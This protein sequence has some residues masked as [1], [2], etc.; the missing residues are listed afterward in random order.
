M[1]DLLKVACVQMSS[2]P[3][4][5][6][7]FKAAEKMI[8]AAAAD[9]CSFIATPE[10]TCHMSFPLSERLKTAQ[11]SETHPGIPFF[12]QLAQELRVWVLIGSMAVKISDNKLLNRSFLFSD[13]GD[14]VAMYD[15]IHLFDVK[16]ADGE[17]YR[18]SDIMVPG[19]RAVV[20]DMDGVNVGLSICYDVRFAA[21][22]RDLAKMRA[23]IL[24]VPAAF[25]VPTGQAHWEVLLRAR[26]IETGSFVMA[27]GQ[28]GEH[29]GGRK[30]YGHS[31]IIGPWGDILAQAGEDVGYI[32]AELDLE[33]VIKA[34]TAI[35]ALKHD[36]EY[37]VD[38]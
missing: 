6:E 9:G 2:G 5:D 20:A 32:T 7:N 30:T 26:A 10:N 1:A 23:Q 16:L 13:S 31:M 3:V 34:R 25:T 29:A 33:N 21:L 8:R 22:Y 18:E 12:S 37:E 15:K 36:R 35:P 28:T 4:M 14:L 38:R 27:P 17:A 19:G 24:A 11:S